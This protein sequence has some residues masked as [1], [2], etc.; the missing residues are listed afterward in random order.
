M[1]SKVFALLIGISLSVVLV[2]CGGD[3]GTI[4]TS[5]G[6]ATKMTN[7]SAGEEFY[8]KSCVGCHG[9]NLEGTVGP[10]L[11]KIGAS[12]NKEEIKT[13]IVDGAPGMPKG[14]VTEDEASQLAE[15]LS[16]KK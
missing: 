5:S 3:E 8:K 13:I 7:A 6:S 15:W 12:K 14:L 4:G 10:A 1:K 9:G 2:A 16:T 11:N